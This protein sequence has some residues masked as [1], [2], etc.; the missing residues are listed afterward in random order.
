MTWFEPYNQSDNIVDIYTYSEPAQVYPQWV[1]PYPTGLNPQNYTQN[2]TVIINGVDVNYSADF[3]GVTISPRLL[4]S[5]GGMWCDNNQC[6]IGCPTWPYCKAF[7]IYSYKGS[8]DGCGCLTEDN[9][10]NEIYTRALDGDL[11]YP[12]RLINP[13]DESKAA[14]WNNANLWFNVFSNGYVLIKND[15]PVYGQPGGEEYLITVGHPIG[16]NHCGTASENGERDF[17]FFDSTINQTIYRRFVCPCVAWDLPHTRHAV[18]LGSGDACGI[19]NADPLFYALSHESYRLWVMKANQ[20]PIPNY[21][22]RHKMLLGKLPRNQMSTSNGWPVYSL[23][24]H[25][26]V[27]KCLMYKNTTGLVGVVPDRKENPSTIAY[28]GIDSTYTRTDLLGEGDD[29]HPYFTVTQS[30]NPETIF[31]G[32]HGLSHRFRSRNIPTICGPANSLAAAQNY[33]SLDYDRKNIIFN[34]N[35]DPSIYNPSQIDG[36]IPT[37]L[38]TD[39]ARTDFG[40]EGGGGAEL[41]FITQ[42]MLA[43]LGKPKIV[44]YQFPGE[45]YIPDV[46]YLGDISEYANKYPLRHL[47]YLSRESINNIFENSNTVVFNEQR[48]LQAAEL[49]EL[50]EKFYKN[51]SLTIKFYNKWLTKSNLLQN[52]TDIFGT[53]GINFKQ[54]FNLLFDSSFATVNTITPLDSSSITVYNSPDNIYTIKINPNYY[55]I[56]SQYGQYNYDPTHGAVSSGNAANDIDYINILET[57]TTNINLTDMTEDQICFII[58]TIDH[59]NNITCNEYPELKDNSGGTINAPC[60]ASRNLLRIVDPII[61]DLIMISSLGISSSFEVSN[62]SPIGSAATDS[63]PPKYLAAYAKKENGVITF[64]HSNGIKILTQLQQ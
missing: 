61:S 7:F 2:Q 28:K 33:Y 45:M 39:P 49:N 52:A 16:L 15:G 20:D 18:Y 40:V 34:T 9:Y 51:Q 47:P 63:I 37:D 50:Q 29:G 43:S 17:A 53:S 59:F 26:R 62:D 4:G 64:Y 42:P 30:E 55:R 8:T 36:Y 31:I 23:D 13:M 25:L 46:P 44:F 5:N 32:W 57:K 27:S 38:S 35:C 60:G 11:V 21:I 6:K 56:V 10:R 48:M 3:S 1:V 54:N 22:T 24:A 58:L 41:Y 12:T 14:F 19:S